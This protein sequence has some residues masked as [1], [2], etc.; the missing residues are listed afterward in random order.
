MEP[1]ATINIYTF[2]GK[3]T[4]RPRRKLFSIIKKIVRYESVNRKL[5]FCYRYILLF[6]KKIILSLGNSIGKIC[7][8]LDNL[9]SIEYISAPFPS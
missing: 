6:L 4:V 9:I 7:L 5:L 8:I 1:E 3:Y 2:Y